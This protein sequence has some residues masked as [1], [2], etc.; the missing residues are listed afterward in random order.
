MTDIEAIYE[1]FKARKPVKAVTTCNHTQ[2]NNSPRLTIG[3]VP[4]ES[5]DSIMAKMFSSEH[6][7]KIKRLFDGDLSDYDNDAS[8]A[9]LGLCGYLAYW[10]NKDP[11]TMDQIFRQSKLYRPK[12]DR[13]DYSERTL[14]LAIESSVT[15]NQTV[16]VVVPVNPWTLEMI[17]SSRMEPILPPPGYVIP[18]LL[19]RQTVGVIPGEGGNAK[20]SMACLTLCLQGAVAGTFPQKWLGN[21]SLE[22]FTSIY[23]SLEDPREQVQRR[24]H[25][26]VDSLFPDLEKRKKAWTLIKKNFSMLGKEDFNIGQD[27]TKVVDEKA[28]ATYKFNWLQDLLNQ[29][30]P[31]L[32]I[33]DTKTKLGGVE[34]NDN[35]LNSGMMSIIGSLCDVEYKPSVIMT[36]HVSKAVRSGVEQHNMNAARGAGSIMDDARWSMWFKPM[37]KKDA[38]GG[39]LIEV[40]HTKNSYGGLADAIVVSF[41]YPRF[42]LT[43]LT[44]EVL[45]Q[46]ERASKDEDLKKTILSLLNENKD[47]LS[48]R[49]IREQVKRGQDVV[50]VTLELLIQMKQIET[51]GKGPASKYRLL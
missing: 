16:P 26:I 22:E 32:V 27:F 49:D 4:L 5:N 37:G 2:V 20:K 21:W 38:D 7:E 39:D 14:A 41:K 36:C 18:D 29:I 30:R 13:Q 48:K 15:V 9:D 42:T 33:F 28:K 3:G 23:V 12:W 44:A 35:A 19:P 51:A 50:G 47:G 34:E 46:A 31:E 24:I 10:C 43:N 1:I 25:S 6:G 45:K 17:S 40:Q 8:R 11:G